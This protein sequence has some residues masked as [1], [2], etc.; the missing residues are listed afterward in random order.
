MVK[1]AIISFE[2]LHAWGY[3]AALEE[4]S[5]TDF[6]AFFEDNPET[7]ARIK[8]KHPGSKAYQSYEKLLEESGCEAVIVTSANVR[9]KEHVIAAAKAGKH[10]LCEKPIATTMEDAREMIE[11]CRKAGVKLG[12]AF[13]V[14]YSPAVKRA[15]DLIQSKK[16]GKLLAANT[17]NHGSMPG[18]W[19]AK[20]ELSGGG[21]V[22]DHTVH[23][24]DL[25]RYMLNQEITKVYAT[26]G[27]NLHSM[28]VEDC[29]LLM[30]ELSGG[31]FVTLDS[32]WSRPS[33][34]PLWGDVKLDFKGTEGNLSVNC[35]PWLLNLYQNST[36]KHTTH[37][38]GD[39]IDFELVEDFARSIIEDR[40]PLVTGEDGLRA[41]EVTLAAFRSIEEKR[42]VSLPL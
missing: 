20:K 26:S 8:E 39:N 5:L 6:C 1:V 19:F 2:H 16:L 13:P 28:E 42:P 9:H 21:A 30:L 31:A 11:E 36:N 32:S 40:E 10:V 29:G 18:G 17:T 22:M 35:F 3:S 15:R 33:C 4:S 37:P 25:L 38:G 12:T 34:Y 41:L 27:N 14:R 7:F 24:T 23:V